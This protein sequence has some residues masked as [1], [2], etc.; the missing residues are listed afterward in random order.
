MGTLRGRKIIMSAMRLLLIALLSLGIFFRLAHLDHKVF[1][2]DETF[3][4]LR[5]S[6]YT[7]AEFVQSFPGTSVVTAS[8]LRQFQT[9]GSDKTITDTW[10]SLATEDNQ[11][12][13]F[14]YVLASLWSRWVGDTI[15]DYRL[16]PALFALLGFPAM[17]WLCQE[18]FVETGV[19]N[20]SLPAWVGV[21]IFAV[22]PF[23]IIY[24]QEAR[25]YSLW[26]TTIL[27]STATL[28]WAIRVQTDGRWRLYAVTVAVNLY[29]FLLSGLVMVAH[30]TYL[31]LH[32]K[33]QPKRRYWIAYLKASLAATA[34]FLPW[35]R[36]LVDNPD[37]AQ[38]VTGWTTFQQPLSTM[39]LAWFS[40]LGRIFYDRGTTL[41]DQ[42][43]KLWVVVLIAYA[44]YALCRHTP[45]RV[46]LLVV[47]LTVIPV[48]PLWL[49]DLLL[50]GL[51]ST[52]P[53]YFIAT[54]LGIQLA[55]VYL[56]T[57]KLSSLEP[58]IRN[59]GRVMT[60]AVCCAG[61]VSAVAS[62]QAQTWWL[63]NLNQENPAIVQLI[64]Q[65]ARPL[66]VSDGES[67]EILSLSHSLKSTVPLLIHPRCYTCH[68][69]TLEMFDPTLDATL[70][71]VSK[72]Y[73]DVFL[74]HPRS[75]Q[76]WRQSLKNNQNFRFELI[77]LKGT[78][79][80]KVLWRIVNK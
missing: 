28:L 48:L 24:A 20:S 26:T 13:P 15:A 70:L 63:K 58:R 17:Y 71:Q 64:E 4:A 67:G 41:I 34:V 12:S 18:L 37:Q 45:R 78:K 56:L 50:G 44:F 65:S 30:A 53:R 22:S 27:W 54:I 6:G 62:F 47:T 1:W 32:D 25:Q 68:L 5:A 7:E 51:R 57:E 75:S 14:Y 38:T 76:I 23:H 60:I 3:T 9:P 73:R 80:D 21:G 74:Y 69:P 72:D 16:L 66:L 36:V 79:N 40:V 10:R 29:T 46:W 33:L 77:P 43:I 49:P 35:I 8:D 11:H 55:V 31:L 42:F 2:Y 52:F 61:I 19:F 59:W 39:V